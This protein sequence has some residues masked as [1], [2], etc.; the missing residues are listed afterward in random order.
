VKNIHLAEI[1]HQ[2]VQVY[3]KGVMNEGNMRKHDLN[4]CLSPPRMPTFV[5]TGDSLYKSV[6]NI[7]AIATE[8]FI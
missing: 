7:P 5:K 2:P 4:A 6:N 8:S 1:H 3:G